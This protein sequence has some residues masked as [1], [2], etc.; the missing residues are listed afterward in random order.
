MRKLSRMVKPWRDVGTLLQLIAPKRCWPPY[1]NSEP[2]EEL[3]RLNPA[4]RA[5]C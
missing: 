3:W 1:E 2:S 4:K 5:Q